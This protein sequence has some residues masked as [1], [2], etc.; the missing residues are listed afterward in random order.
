L[1]VPQSILVAPPTAD[2]WEGQT[3]EDEMGFPYDFVELFTTY[4]RWDKKDQDAFLK[5]LDKESLEYFRTTGEKAKKIHDRNAHK[6][7]W[8]VNI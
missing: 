8:P 1:N 4:L 7:S 3:D 6:A 2:L 5:R